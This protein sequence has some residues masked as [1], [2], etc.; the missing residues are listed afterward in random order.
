[1][2]KEVEERYVSAIEDMVQAKKEENMNNF[3]YYAGV[4]NGIRSA[5]LAATDMSLEEYMCL[6]DMERKVWF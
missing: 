6:V 5:M 4:V 2:N 3:Y 1:M